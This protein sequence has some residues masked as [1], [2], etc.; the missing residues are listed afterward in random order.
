MRVIAEADRIVKLSAQ[1]KHTGSVPFSGS[2][3]GARRARYAPEIINRSAKV[4]R[5]TLKSRNEKA[6]L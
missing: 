3:A 1:R 5:S 6:Q 2:S 4:L